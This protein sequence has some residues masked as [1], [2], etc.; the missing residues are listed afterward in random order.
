MHKITISLVA[1][2][3]LAMVPQARA[4]QLFPPANIGAN[5]NS[6]CPN[7]QVLGWT[8]QGV[9]CTDPTP[10][11]TT[12]NVCPSGYYADA[13]VKGGADCK[14]LTVV[15]N[16]G[17]YLEGIINGSADCRS[18][19]AVCNPGYYL[20]GIINGSADCKPLPTTPTPP[21][22]TCTGGYVAITPNIGQG[23]S[24]QYIPSQTTNMG[25]FGSKQVGDQV[26][27]SMNAGCWTC[28]EIVQCIGGTTWSVITPPG[29]ASPTSC[30]YQSAPGL[31][32]DGT[33]D[34]GP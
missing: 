33:A 9:N 32:P 29:E 30:V 11:V 16:S 31:S 22:T 25:S 28:S 6:P 17:Y 4:D 10:G 1:F 27:I 15:C 13:I 34:C 3:A 20:E 18:V 2:C 12:T 23:G 14:P 21:P 8:G 26:T 19:V 5:A 7:G 24:F